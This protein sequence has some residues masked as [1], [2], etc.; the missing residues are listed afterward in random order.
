[1]SDRDEARHALPG[2]APPAVALVLARAGSK[3]VPGKNTA[4]IAGKPCV[5]WT[6]EA[7][8]RSSV[9]R[10]VV[11][12]DDAR[13][14]EVARG[15]GV[16]VVERPAA[17][18]SDAARIDDAARHAAG[19]AFP[20]TH[21]VV[22][23]YANVPVRPARLIDDALDL[24]RLGG[25]DSVQSF[26]PVGKHH[27]WW[28]VRVDECTGELRPWE[29]ERLFHDVFRRQDLP[30][31]YVPDGGVMALTRDS[32]F[33]RR[34]DEPSHPHA[35]LGRVRRAVVTPPGSVIDIDSG[36]DLEVARAAL[37]AAD[38]GRERHGH[39]A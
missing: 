39:A 33:L 8:L 11:S 22:I 12:T 16:E 6:I 19:V 35:F 24:L 17:L 32:L 25:C 30:A 1:M 26:T 18:A 28:T 29:G 5:A 3:G 21:H 13:V 2:K 20:Q 9:A 36:L 7:A 38:L 10:V 27:P 14:G 23:L 31:A 37:R 34:T 15:L 4:D